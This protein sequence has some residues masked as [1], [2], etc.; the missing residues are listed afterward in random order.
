MENF[1]CVHQMEWNREFG[2]LRVEKKYCS[3]I[4]LSNIFEL[5][6]QLEGTLLSVP[7]NSGRVSSLLVCSFFQIHGVISSTIGFKVMSTIL[8]DKKRRVLSMCLEF[9]F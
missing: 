4:G 9:T 2:P 1:C 3:S 8:Q 5:I 6:S 7:F